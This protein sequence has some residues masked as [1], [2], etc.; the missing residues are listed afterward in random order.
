MLVGNCKAF[1]TNFDRQEYEDSVSDN[2]PFVI[3]DSVFF[4]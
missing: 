2:S 4:Q 3:G 1:L